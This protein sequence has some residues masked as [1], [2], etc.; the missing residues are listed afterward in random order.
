M[1][2]ALKDVSQIAD[3][4]GIAVISMEAGNVIGSAAM[5]RLVAAIQYATGLGV[6]MEDL[7]VEAI[8]WYNAWHIERNPL[9]G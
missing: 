9:R 1:K 6:G 2:Q 8:E 4:L 7:P 5:E 3:S